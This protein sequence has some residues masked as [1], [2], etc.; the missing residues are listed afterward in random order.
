MQ[1]ENHA[2][3]HGKVSPLIIASPG[4]SKGVRRFVRPALFIAAGLGLGILMIAL[5]TSLYRV[6]GGMATLVEV[7]PISYAYAAGLVAAVNPCGILFVPSL[8]AYYVGA[9]AGNESPP[10]ERG[11]RA[12]IFGTVAT[13]GFLTLFA[14]VG[15]VFVAGGRAIASYFPIG[16]LAVGVGFTALGLWMILTGGSVGFASASRALGSVQVRGDVR[17]PYLFGLAY[18]VASLACTLPV[19]LVVVGTSLL[20]NDPVQA[21][22]QFLAYALGMGTVLTA[23]VV[24]ATFFQSA[25]S[26]A[27]R[28]V[29][30]YMHELMAAVL[31][32]TGL[33]VFLYW[34]EALGGLP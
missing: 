18:G 33:F 17:S 14:A 28:W 2:V 4:T 19:F 11:A 15:A 21:G 31:L 24:G 26:R 32:G 8:A 30:P 3:A 7:L 29:V 34:L 13:L 22:R 25:V 5:K 16:G 1:P 23:V 9:T 10:W 20:G 27:T 6:Q 12:L